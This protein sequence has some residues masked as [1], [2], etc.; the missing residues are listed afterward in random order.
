[1]DRYEALEVKEI[2]AVKRN[3]CPC[4]E[5]LESFSGLEMIPSFLFCPKCNNK[6]YAFDGTVLFEL[7]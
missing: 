4:G 1:M 7:E 6:A 3:E 2:M 5:P